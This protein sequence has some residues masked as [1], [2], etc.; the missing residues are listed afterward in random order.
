MDLWSLGVILYELYVGQPPFYT[1]SIYS[2]IHHIVKDPVKFPTNISAEFKSFLKVML[3]IQVFT[4]AHELTPSQ[5][6]PPQQAGRGLVSIHV[7]GTA[8]DRSTIMHDILM[9]RDAAGQGCFEPAVS[10]LH[11]NAAFDTCICQCRAC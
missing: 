10:H 5:R 9:A 7:M 11:N 8:W 4:T 3:C 6:G 2:L 1:N